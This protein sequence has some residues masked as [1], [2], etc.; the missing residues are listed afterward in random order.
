MSN[1]GLQNIINEL[2]EMRVEMRRMGA[3]AEMLNTLEFLKSA[4]PMECEDV[5]AALYSRWITLANEAKE[6]EGH[7]G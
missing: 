7:H 5:C 2:R 6:K 1:E 3:R 4:T